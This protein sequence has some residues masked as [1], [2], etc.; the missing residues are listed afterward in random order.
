ML[1][2]CDMCSRYIDTQ[3]ETGMLPLF[4]HLKSH[5]LVVEVPRALSAK[6]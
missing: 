3:D 1:Y 6:A 2:R 5:G 4:E